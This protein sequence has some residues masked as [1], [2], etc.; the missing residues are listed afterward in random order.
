MYKK[1]ISGQRSFHPRD[2]GLDRRRSESGTELKPGTAADIEALPDAREEHMLNEQTRPLDFGVKCPRRGGCLAEPGVAAI[3]YEQTGPRPPGVPLSPGTYLALA[4]RTGWWIPAPCARSRTGGAPRRRAGS[5]RSRSRR[6]INVGS[7]TRSTL[8]RWTRWRGRGVAGA[9]AVRRFG[10]DS[11]SVAL[12]MTSF[13]TFID[14]G[15]A[16]APIAQRVNAKRK[17]CVPAPG[18]SGAIL[19]P[20]WRHPAVVSRLILQ[21][22]RC[23]P[24]PADDHYHSA[25]H[26]GL[27]RRGWAARHSR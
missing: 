11:S 16:R 22:A 8:C 27:I 10:L 5:A 20:R 15:Y 24:V 18:R 26:H 19:H 25:Q 14:T 13:A 2:E 1:V 7:G 23:H 21:Q 17:R 3:S 4:A 9:G 6:W 12:V